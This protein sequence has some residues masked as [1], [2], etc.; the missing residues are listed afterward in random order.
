MR[1]Q[2]DDCLE[3]HG[4]LSPAG[5]GQQTLDRE[6]LGWSAKGEGGA[7]VSHDNLVVPFVEQSPD[8]ERVGLE[9]ERREYVVGDSEITGGV[10]AA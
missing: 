6:W 3:L 7:V 2:G 9:Q 5:W 8:R 10:A 1:R 4:P